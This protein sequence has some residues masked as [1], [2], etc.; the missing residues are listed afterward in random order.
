SYLRLKPHTWSAGW[1]SLAEQDREA[2]LRICPT[3]TLGGGDPARQFNV[4]FRAADATANPYLALAVI[5]RA[6]LEGLRRK[7]PAPPLVRGDPETMTV[8]ERKA[9]GLRRLPDS[10]PAAIAAFEADPVVRGWFTSEFT[11][12][13]LGVRRAELAKV[14]GLDPAAICALYGSLY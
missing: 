1:T 2:A 3:T 6:G 13:F 9:A 11:E 7:L 8:P 5:I 4:E 14:E 10:L 12:S